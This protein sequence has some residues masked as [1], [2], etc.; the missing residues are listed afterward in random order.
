MSEDDLRSRE[1]N[2][3]ELWIA[4]HEKETLGK[5]RQER[6]DRMAAAERQRGEQELASLRDAHWHRCPKCG[7]EMSDSSEM[8]GAIICAFCEGVYLEQPQLHDL[9]LNAA[10]DRRGVFRRLLSLR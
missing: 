10:D 9:M 7:H 5:I 4:E 3:E 6:A 8:G 1:R 2:S